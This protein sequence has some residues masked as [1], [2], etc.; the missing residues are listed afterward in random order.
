MRRPIVMLAC[1]FL[2]LAGTSSARAEFIGNAF[3]GQA[4]E[5][6]RAAGAHAFEGYQSFYAGM[7]QLEK[8]SAGAARENFQVA[9]GRF[10]D[11][12]KEYERAATMLKGKALDLSR[13]DPPQKQLLLQFLGPFK[14]T[15][16]SDQ[17]AILQAYASS[18]AQT[19]S[20]IEDGS[21]EMTLAKFRQV[22]LTINRQI[23]VG[24]FI[25]RALGR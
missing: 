10:Q 1:A 11:S 14:A 9:L 16:T 21:K 13:L 12:Q 7:S 8:R 22:Q 2:M 20:L 15:E 6:T 25:S 19:A 23:L 24:T 3:G 5:T 4:E 18:F 17:E